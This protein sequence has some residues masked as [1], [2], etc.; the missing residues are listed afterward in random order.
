MQESLYCM[1]YGVS[2]SSFEPDIKVQASSLFDIFLD[3]LNFFVPFTSTYSK[4]NK[5]PYD[6]MINFYLTGIGKIYV[7]ALKQPDEAYN[8]MR[9]LF[10]VV[11]N[12]P[13]YKELMNNVLAGLLEKKCITAATAE[14]LLNQQLSGGHKRY[15]GPEWL[16]KENEGKLLVVQIGDSQ[17]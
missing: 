17:S 15:T 9:S 3:L 13:E 4:R 10:E 11:Y 7:E 5:I 16:S 6:S 12:F 2:Y 1:Q 8:T 14:K